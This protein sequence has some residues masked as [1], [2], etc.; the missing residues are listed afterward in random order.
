M[1]GLINLFLIA[2]ES[3]G[4][5]VL[6][7]MWYN[8]LVNNPTRNGDCLPMFTF[9]EYVKNVRTYTEYKFICLKCNHE[10]LDYLVNG[11]IPVCDNS[12]TPLVLSSKYEDELIQY[13]R[14]FYSGK[15]L[16]SNRSLLKTTSTL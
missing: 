8:D 12:N 2:L 6:L 13:I 14:T 7:G 4:F 5:G 10:F 11:H 1:K 9:E 16:K 15:L 3:F